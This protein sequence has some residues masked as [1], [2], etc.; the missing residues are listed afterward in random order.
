[1]RAEKEGDNKIWK[2][3]ICG[4]LYLQ[5]SAPVYELPR[6][7]TGVLTLELEDPYDAHA[8]VKRNLL[9]LSWECGNDPRGPPKG[10]H[11]LDALCSGHSISPSLRFFRSG[12]KQ[13]PFKQKPE[14]SS[15]KPFEPLTPPDSQAEAEAR[16]PLLSE[17]PP[18]VTP[19]DSHQ[20]GTRG[21][22]PWP[23]TKRDF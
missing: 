4:R 20:L 17:S 22:T 8:P 21:G 5:Q 1:M 13:H 9:V 6:S 2:P 7:P 18:L 23:L 14:G 16:R 10:N 11:H 12:R 19:W 3:S 15:K